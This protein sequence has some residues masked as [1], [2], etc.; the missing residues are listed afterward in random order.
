[1]VAAYNNDLMNGYGFTIHSLKEEVI[2]IIS[3]KTKF[4]SNKAMF[5]PNKL[6]SK[7]KVRSQIDPAKG[8]NELIL[9]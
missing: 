1:M 3:N 7:L 2:N 8:W 9:T 4:Q 5:Y 6:F